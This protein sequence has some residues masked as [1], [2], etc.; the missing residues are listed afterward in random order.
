M[1]HEVSIRPPNR[2]KRRW[3]FIL[4]VVAGAMFAM[5]YV[6]AFTKN[7]ADLEV[8]PRD[9]TLTAI[10]W[11]IPPDQAVGKAAAII[12]GLKR[13]T[14]EASDAKAGTLHAIHKTP[15]WRFSD[16]VNLRFE[17]IPGGTRIT[18]RSQSR[19]GK[20]DLGQNARNLRELASALKSAG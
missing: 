7:W 13:W 17:P 4:I 14:V 6:D 9:P 2:P 20:A 5:S 19:I 15:F 12:A 18:G 8:N 11:A 1:S 10:V 16:D 3:L